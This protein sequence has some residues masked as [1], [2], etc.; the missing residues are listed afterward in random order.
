MVQRSTK[1][2]FLFL[3]LA[4]GL[5]SLEEYRGRLWENFPP[6]R[7]LCG[8]V[9]DNPEQGFIILNLLLF[10]FGMICW[11]FVF[12]DKINLV[13]L[14]LWIV[15]EMIN[16]IG[17]PAWAIYTQAYAPG[18]LTSPILFLLAI[19]LAKQLTSSRPDV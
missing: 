6:A 15:I 4:Q 14:W 12:W 18:M 5:H 7:F 16:G 1:I 19:Y 2:S 17:H 3:V 11:L 10:L 8:L 13:F 9:S